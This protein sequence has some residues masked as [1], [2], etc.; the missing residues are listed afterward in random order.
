ML[1]SCVTTENN[2]V[3]KGEKKIKR[4]ISSKSA[5]STMVVVNGGNGSD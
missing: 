4:E 2:K 1:I 3:E 5:K